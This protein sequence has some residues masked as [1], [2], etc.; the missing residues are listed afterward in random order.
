MSG[1]ERRESAPSCSCESSEILL[2]PCSGGSNVGQI[3]N[4]VAVRLTRDGQAKMFCLA[5][6]G[7]DLKQMIEPTKSAD[8]RVAIDGCPV[9][10]AVATLRRHGLEPE[11]ALVVTELGIEKNK[12][13]DLQSKH[14][15]Q[16]REALAAS[17]WDHFAKQR[18][19]SVQK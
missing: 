13:F 3:A 12:N 11:V 4:A 18:S 17:I 6:L 2:F 5:G 14:L 19:P 8:V 9:G 16:V 10:C 7:G 1:A 15:D